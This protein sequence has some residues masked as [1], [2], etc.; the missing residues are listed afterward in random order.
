MYNKQIMVID[1]FGFM[2]STPMGQ[3]MTNPLSTYIKN[4]I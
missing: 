2:E 4:D 1:M 3:L